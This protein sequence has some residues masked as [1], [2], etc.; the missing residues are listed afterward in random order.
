MDSAES[1]LASD[2]PYENRKFKGEYAFMMA[3]MCQK[4]AIGK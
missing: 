3:G 4:A 1:A 2:P